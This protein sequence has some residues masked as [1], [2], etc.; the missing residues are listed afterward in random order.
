MRQRRVFQRVILLVVTMYRP[1]DVCEQPDKCEGKKSG[2]AKA[3]NPDGLSRCQ[4][5]T[6]LEHRPKLKSQ[7]GRPTRD[8]MVGK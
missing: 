1:G 3:G 6:D 5:V 2:S 7:S 8:E 4:P